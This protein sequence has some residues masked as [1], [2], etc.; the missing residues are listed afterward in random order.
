L[1]QFKSMQMIIVKDVFGHFYIYLNL[2]GHTLKCLASIEYII[3]KR[4]MSSDSVSD[5]IKTVPRGPR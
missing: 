1:Q 2:L 5:G 3:K 4:E